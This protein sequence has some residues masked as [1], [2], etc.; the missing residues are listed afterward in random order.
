LT[1]RLLVLLAFAP[2]LGGASAA[3]AAT[4]VLHPV[5]DNT[6]Y[7]GGVTG[8]TFTDNSCGAGPDVFAGVT[9]RNWIRR[10]LLRFDVASAVPAGSTIDAVTLTLNVNLTTDT[11]DTTMTLHPVLQAWGE[12]TVDCRFNGGGKG[13]EAGLG[14]ATWLDAKFQQVPWSSAGGDFGA[15]SASAVVPI[16]GDA[17]WDSTANPGMRI[18]VQSWLD[19]PPDN[20]GWIVVDDEIRIRSARR[21]GSR[22]GNPPPVLSVEFTP[23]PAVFACCFA[24]GDCTLDEGASCSA[25]GGTPDLGSNS[26]EPNPCPQPIG[27]CCNLEETCSD[28]V[29]RDVCEAAS[30]VFQGDGSTCNDVAVDCGLEPYV[31]SLPLPPVLQP[32]GT[33]QSGA[34]LYEVT[35]QTA[36]Q[37]LHSELPPTDLWTYN[38]MFPGPTIE[39]DVGAPIE[40]RYVNAL[41]ATGGHALPVDECSHGPNFWQDTAR[42][43]THLHGGHVAARFDGQPEFHILPGELDEYAYP[44]QQLPAT[45][46]YHDHAMGIT[47]LNV[48]MGLA[49]F[50]LLRDDFERNLGL[51]DGEFEIPLVLQD[52]AF[53]PDGSL[54]YPATIEDAFY[55]DKVLV[56]GKVWPYHDVKQG[57]YRLR[58]LNGSQARVYRLKLENPADP[59][60]VIPFE[61]IGTDGGLIGAPISLQEIELAPA[62]R[63]DVVVDFAAFPAGTEIVLRNQD[64]T[65]P[66]V[67]NTMKFVVGSA[68]GFSGSIPSSL[69]PVVPIPEGEATQERK[70]HFV[71]QPDPCAGKRWLISSIGPDNNLLG[72]YWDDVTEF[73]VLGETEI[74]EVVNSSNMMHPFH[75]HL[76][77]FQVLDRTDM[78]TGNLM[79]LDPWEV[80]SWKDTVKLPPRT[81]VRVIAKFEDYPGRFAYH[82]HILDHEDHEMMRQ[83]QTVHDPANCVVDGLCDAGEDCQSCPAD[84]GTV[85]GGSCGNGLCEIG[86]GEDCVSCPADC[87]GEQSGGD[88]FCCGDGAGIGPIERCG[89]DTDGFTLLDD[90]CTSDGY[91]CRIMPRLS[92]CCGD[93]LCEGQEAEAGPDACDVDCVPVPEPGRLW[94]LAAGIACLTALGSRRGVSR[95]R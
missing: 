41:P 2:L 91:F 93:A 83:F 92:A 62:E 37:Q 67:P 88:P 14:D 32:I 71:L 39:A 68:M 56:N 22:E 64:A 57:K 31:D 30:G 78:V 76:V 27:A 72:Q 55:G 5:A 34:P 43:V 13:D 48:Y 63:F 58:L 19:A 49:G 54:S 16:L 42:I 25:Q 80:D 17:V 10:A 38:G 94:M 23:P 12:G 21:F 51:P 89:F 60:A 90:R 74:W 11:L 46:W 79:P 1:R 81:R 69:R 73:P 20:H 18:D 4:V 8:E 59:G 3:S 84:C 7:H 77:M 61:L 75:M 65:E 70:F 85:S 53:H 86:D 66:R 6:I 24:N 47:R 52:R 33:S 28:P 9:A 35:I 44:N 29:A 95:T 26:C 50:Y 45:L 40:V 36:S 15:A 87:A 82:C